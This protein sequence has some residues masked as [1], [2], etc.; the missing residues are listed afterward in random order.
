M[1]AVQQEFYLQLH[2]G[3]NWLSGQSDSE[4]RVVSCG[5]V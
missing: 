4:W 1:I 5:K 3:S 2:S